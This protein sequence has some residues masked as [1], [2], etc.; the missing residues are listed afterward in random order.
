MFEL[1]KKSGFDYKQS[2]SGRQPEYSCM[3]V[4][5]FKFW[6]KKKKKICF[7]VFLVCF[8]VFIFQVFEEQTMSSVQ[9][10]SMGVVCF[11]ISRP[12]GPRREGI[13]GIHEVEVLDSNGIV[14]IVCR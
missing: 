4:R 5:M 9:T 3:L 7:C 6:K 2:A 11:D 10:T 8:C 13:G 14:S 1:E 12:E